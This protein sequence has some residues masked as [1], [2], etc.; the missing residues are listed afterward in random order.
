MVKLYETQ[1]INA[2]LVIRN[3]GAFN[4]KSLR[5]ICRSW[6]MSLTTQQQLLV[7]R[8]SVVPRQRQLY[9]TVG[10]IQY[11]YAVNTLTAS[12][13]R[14]FNIQSSH[15][16]KAYERE[17]FLCYRKSPITRLPC[18]WDH[19]AARSAC[20]AVMMA[21]ISDNYHDPASRD[22]GPSNRL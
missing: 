10:I 11:G 1:R 20:T 19:L 17:Q 3:S 7:L 2:F 13:R 14:L 5:R 9:Q 16:D 21:V 22:R 12:I 4:C 15:A 6:R 8:L 18:Q